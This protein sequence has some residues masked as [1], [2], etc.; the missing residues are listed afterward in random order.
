M[1]SKQK[2]NI[3]AKTMQKVVL[4]AVVETKFCGLGAQ[5]KT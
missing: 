3:G 5:K 4:K 2:V 1:V